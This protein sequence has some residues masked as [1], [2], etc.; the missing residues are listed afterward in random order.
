VFHRHHWTPATRCIPFHAADANL[1][2]QDGGEPQGHA[3]CA[4]IA[5]MSERAVAVTGRCRG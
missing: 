5:E 1:P 2:A 4:R 3:P